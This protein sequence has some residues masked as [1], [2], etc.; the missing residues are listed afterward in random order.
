MKAHSKFSKVEEIVLDKDGN[1]KCDICTKMGQF[2]VERK[3]DKSRGGLLA[4]FEQIFSQIEECL[5]ITYQGSEDNFRAFRNTL[6]TILRETATN[7][8]VVV[9]KYSIDN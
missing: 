7:L 2:L 5:K 8:L 6:H 9:N 1:V 4:K 3:N